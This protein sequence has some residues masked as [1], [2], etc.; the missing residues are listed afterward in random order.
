MALRLVLSSSEQSQAA[1]L[2]S[3]GD[4]GSIAIAIGSAVVI[5]KAEGNINALPR[6]R[7]CSRNLIIPVYND[8]TLLANKMQYSL[9]EHEFGFA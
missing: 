4:S 3:S 8:P 6:A 5:S 2:K 9:T 1:N 7:T